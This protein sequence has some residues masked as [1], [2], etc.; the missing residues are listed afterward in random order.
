LPGTARADLLVRYLGYSSAMPANLKV[1]FGR[2]LGSVVFG[3]ARV[4]SSSLAKNSLWVFS[5]QGASVV[6][7]AL[8]FIVIARLLTPGEYG[9]YIGAAAFVSMVSSYSSM[10]SGLVFLRHASQ[11]HSC[12][13]EYFGNI[14]LTTG[15]MGSVLALG[16]HYS[17]E[18]L[19]GRDSVRL[20]TV[21]AVGDL[22]FASLAMSMSQVFQAFELMRISALIGLL[23]SVSRLATA[24]VLL[25]ALHRTTALT[26]AY[27]SVGISSLGAILS[28]LTALSKFGRPRFRPLSAVRQAGEGLSFAMTGTA[29]GACNDIDKV[30]LVHFGM[31]AANGV[32]AMAYRVVDVCTLPIRSVHTAAFPRLFRLGATGV[33]PAFQF[34]SRL[35]WRTA[36]LALAAVPCLL[37][38]APLVPRLI[39]PNY[40]A[41]VSAMRWLSL[42]P[43]LRSLHLSA[44]D[45][46][47]GIGHQ[48]LRLG[49]QFVAAFLNVALN[50]FL[51][52]KFSWHGAAWSSLATDGA[53]AAMCWIA[54]LYLVRRESRLAHSSSPALVVERAL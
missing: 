23:V 6:I 24:V 30:M 42:V 17:A 8:Y 1:T 13:S 50:V 38:S 46:L 36:L 10:G 29:L 39:G 20:I 54:L 35:L 41:S 40:F 5:G 22:F 45:A 15:V 25:A 49:L 28:V 37:L 2:I 18:W 21:V 52:P 32:Y 11:D 44:G 19:A 51:I 48:R 27:A 53:L 26:W 43:V 31:T 7:Q 3:F 16:I 33:G 47:A 9:L 12:C 14:L 34:A 4:G